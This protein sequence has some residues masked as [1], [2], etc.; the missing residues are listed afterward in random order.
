LRSVSRKTS[1]GGL[2]Y[3]IQRLLRGLTRS[4]MLEQESAVV[5]DL[6]AYDEI[7]LDVAVAQAAAE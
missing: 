6:T 7:D 2:K 3:S 4:I 5:P 1:V